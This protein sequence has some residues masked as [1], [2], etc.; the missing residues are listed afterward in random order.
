MERRT[1]FG[2]KQPFLRD[3]SVGQFGKYY[4]DNAVAYFVTKLPK[5]VRLDGEYQKA[6]AEIIYLHNWFNVD[7]KD[8]TDWFAASRQEQTDFRKICIPSGYYAYRSAFET[9]FSQLMD[10]VFSPIDDCN[11]KVVYN[12]T[13]GRSSL[14]VRLTDR[15]ILV[16]SDELQRYTG[17]DLKSIVVSKLSFSM[18]ANETFDAHRGLNLMYIYCD[19]ASYAIVGDTKTP[20]LRVCNVAGKHGEFVRLVYAQPHYVP[21]G[22]REFNSIEIAIN[23]ELGKPMPFQYGKLVIVLHFRRRI[24]PITFIST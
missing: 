5:T 24:W 13:I 3:A 18:M 7:I 2:H 4:P 11:V 10:V 17:L 23:D 21:V 16:I 20:L 14:S 6:L 12:E 1:C 19:V 22:R 9:T 8:G 15:Y